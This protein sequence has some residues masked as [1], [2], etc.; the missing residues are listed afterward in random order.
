MYIYQ[1]DTW[2]DD[3]AERIKDRL[4]PIRMNETG[5]RG[6]YDDFDPDDETT[7]DSDE[8]P[9]GPYDSDESDCPNHCAGCGVFLENDLTTDGADYVRDAVREDMAAGR[10]D[11]I[12]ITEWKPFYDYIDY[13]NLG[14]CNVCGEYAEL[15]EWGECSDCAEDE[16]HVVSGEAYDDYAMPCTT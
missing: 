12:A 10:T 7:F 1:A 16:G 5:D 15:D 11:S 2:C 6:C 3:C 4:L 9:K 13:G 14:L 8:F